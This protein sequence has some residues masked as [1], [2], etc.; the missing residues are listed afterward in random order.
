MQIGSECGSELFARQIAQLAGNGG[1]GGK[2]ATHPIRGYA[3]LLS[4]Q[5]VYQQID[6]ITTWFNV[7]VPR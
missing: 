1:Q 5:A 2:V 3:L 7:S 6:A 4:Q